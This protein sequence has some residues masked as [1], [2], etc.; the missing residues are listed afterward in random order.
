MRRYKLDAMGVV[1]PTVLVC[2]W[3]IASASGALPA[4]KLP[5]PQ[6]L[7][8]VLID[9]ATGT[10]NITPY[11]GTLLSHLLCSLRRVLSG[12]TLATLM[13]ISLGFLTGRV[14]LF[15]R[16]VDPF[17]NMLR[18]IPGIG[19]LPVAIVWFGVGEGNTLFLISL[20]AFFPIYMN[21]AHGAKEVPV[22]ILRAGRMM[23]ARGLNLFATVIFPAA[24]PQVAVGLRLGLGVSW[25]YL[26]LGEVTGVSMG[27]G[28]VMSDGRMLGHVD[29]VLA[30]MLVIAI[31]SKATDRLLLYLCK[32]ISPQ[33]RKRRE[34]R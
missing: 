1:L 10:L 19:W 26:V 31:M 28:A 7:I 25:A 24:F 29:I 32:K 22:L 14:S 13:G 3:F 23:G 17:L 5:S 33:L 8:M 4:Y 18:A 15:Q 12:F 27:L 9:F 34:E 11:S 30:T 6:R 2:I 16:L 20:A 21:T